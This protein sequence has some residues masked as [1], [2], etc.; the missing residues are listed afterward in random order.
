MMVLDASAVI[1]LLLNSRAGQRVAA[2][3][4]DNHPLHVPHLI[5]LEVTQVLR[6]ECALGRLSLERAE[7]GLEVF[8]NLAMR[9]HSHQPL[10]GRIWQLRNNLTAYDACYVALAESLGALL[11]TTDSALASAPHLARVEVA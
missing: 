9:R 6:R 11:L 3:I 2:R 8:Q 1:E 10:L 5:D 7:A 4:S